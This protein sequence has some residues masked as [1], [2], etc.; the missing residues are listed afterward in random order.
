MIKDR[1]DESDIGHEVPCGGGSQL[2]GT[3]GSDD[4]KIQTVQL[5]TSDFYDDSPITSPEED[6]LYHGVFAKSVAKCIL[7]IKNANGGAIA[8]HGPWGSGKSSVINLVSHEL[9]LSE[10]SPIIIPFS[11][12]NYRSEDGI[13][14]GFFQELY[15]GLVEK[16]SIG[17]LNMRRIKKL[18][19][20]AT[21]IVKASSSLITVPYFGVAISAVSDYLGSILNRD[22]KIEDLQKEIGKKL[23]EKGKKILIIIDDIDRLSK[24]E[25]IAIFRLIKSV[26]RLRNVIYLLAYDREITERMIKDIYSFEGSHYLEKIIQANFSLPMPNRSVLT[27]MLSIKLDKIFGNEL[28][29]NSKRTHSVVSDIVVPEIKTPRDVYR[30]VNMLSVTYKPVQGSVNV[31]DFIAL[32][33]VRLFRPQIYQ[34]IQ[35]NKSIL[36]E[37]RDFKLN[38]LDREKFMETVILGSEPAS[39]HS[40]WKKSLMRMFPILDPKTSDFEYD[41]VQE[42]TRDNRVCSELKFDRYFNFSIIGD[43][44]SDKEFLE[45]ARQAGDGGYVRSILRSYADAVDPRSGRTKASFL[46]EKIARGADQV[47]DEDVWDLLVT[48]YSLADDLRS[49]DSDVVRI[50]GHCV[51]NGDRI[52][53][54][55]ESIIMSRD[56]YFDIFLGMKFVYEA[57]PLDLLI[58]LACF[59]EDYAKRYDDDGVEA[60]VEPDNKYVLDLEEAENRLRQNKAWREMRKGEAEELR[61]YALKRIKAAISDCSIFENE[62]VVDILLNWK[63]IANENFDASEMVR[64]TLKRSDKSIINYSKKYSNSLFL[65]FDN[66]ELNQVRL[67]WVNGY[68]DDDKFTSDLSDILRRSD[69][70]ESD[71][72]VVTQLI[73]LIDGDEISRAMS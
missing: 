47:D 39:R 12:W 43:V 57:A 71:R 24:E 13:V 7:E 40:K 5:P 37:S 9:K 63:K 16:N 45:F 64:N 33:T 23:A 27:K 32:E 48:V 42:W 56:E 34:E 41:Y 69:L 36:T 61:K 10:H 20:H 50:F 8:I 53:D 2:Q 54:L 26:G 28:S 38:S 25:A 73:E 6:M 67:S 60:K 55:S 52:I 35:S 66:D 18:G 51:N 15:F 44:V 14:A 49:K 68:A 70:T 22:Q 58:R 59:V 31:A 3:S 46:L 72:D 4:G 1:S 11:S 19:L 29:K 65:D 21:R 30:L 17:V 62:N